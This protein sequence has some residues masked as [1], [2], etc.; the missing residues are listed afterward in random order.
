MPIWFDW[1]ALM[2][3]IRFAGAVLVVAAW[4]GLDPSAARAATAWS[5]NAAA[6]VPL[7]TS[8]L[9]VSAGAVTA[10]SGITVTLYCGI[11]RGA[12]PGAFGRIE[13]T[14]KGGAGVIAQPSNKALKVKKAAIQTKGRITSELVEMSKA[15]GAETVKCAIQAKGSA[16]IKTEENLCNNS[17][18]DFNNNFYYVRISLTSGVLA[19][20]LMTV[21]GSSL[22]SR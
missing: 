4:M 10:G 19:G 17:E 15:T 22:V 13:L 14:Y 3:S 9:S 6:C 16:A 20:H 1:E 18:L 5:T 7:S 12:L 8:G 2:Q 11:T 21:Y